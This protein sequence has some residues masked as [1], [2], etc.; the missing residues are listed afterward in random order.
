M[1][2]LD[3]SR[4]PGFVRAIDDRSVVIPDRKGIREPTGSITNLCGRSEAGSPPWRTRSIER[5]FAT[6]GHTQ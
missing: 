5:I 6:R 4:T 1:R 3:A 2:Y